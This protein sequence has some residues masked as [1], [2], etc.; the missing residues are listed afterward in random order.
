MRTQIWKLS[1]AVTGGL[2]VVSLVSGCGKAKKESAEQIAEQKAIARHERE[3]QQVNSLR[4]GGW[5]NLLAGRYTMEA[6][7]F[8]I[9]LHHNGKLPGTEDAKHSI[10]FH[11]NPSATNYPLSRTFNVK[12][13]S[14][15]FTIH[16]TVVKQSADASWQL[17]KAWRT[18]A[19]GKT[20]RA[21]PVDNSNEP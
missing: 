19:Q 20:V 14:D 9:Q 15:S 18:D 8:L 11:I 3:V 10:Q 16:Y 4:H 17:Q 1:L 6:V 2:I 5:T 7:H 12:T 13:K 21:Y